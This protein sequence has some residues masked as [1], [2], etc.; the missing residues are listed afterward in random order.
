VVKAA[1]RETSAATFLPVSK[2]LIAAG[3][4]RLTLVA[5]SRCS[6]S[7]SSPAVSGYHSPRASDQDD[8]FGPLGVG[9]G[10]GFHGIDTPQ[11]VIYLS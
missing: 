3:P 2:R 5:L 4:V 1:C 10:S 11:I 6:V 9:R 8:Q 7:P